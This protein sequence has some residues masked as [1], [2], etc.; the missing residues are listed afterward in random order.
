MKRQEKRVGKLEQQLTP[1]VERVFYSWAMNPWTPEQAV[2]AMRR[3]PDQ[4]VF[5][6][7]QYERKE[8]T[9]GKMKYPNEDMTGN[10][11]RDWR[12]RA[13]MVH[14]GEWDDFVAM[15]IRTMRKDRSWLVFLL[16]VRRDSAIFV[17]TALRQARGIPEPAR[18]P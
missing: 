12:A 15:P 3:H 7:S 16:A 4:T 5:W 8:D 18:L 6:R 9:A 14:V 10:F 17:A 1:M 11:A 2:A 13:G